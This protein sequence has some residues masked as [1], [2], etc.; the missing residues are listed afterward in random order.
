MNAGQ[1]INDVRLAVEGRTPVKHFG[2]IGGVVPTPDE[3]IHSLKQQF[4]P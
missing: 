2:R 3:I 1:M 4:N